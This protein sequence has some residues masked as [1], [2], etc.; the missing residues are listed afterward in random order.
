MTESTIPAEIYADMHYYSEQNTKLLDLIMQDEGVR[1]KTPVFTKDAEILKIYHQCNDFLTDTDPTSAQYKDF[2]PTLCS[3]PI[4]FGPEARQDIEDFMAM[5]PEALTEVVLNFT[6]N[7]EHFSQYFGVPGFF[8]SLLKSMRF[9][10]K[11]LTMRHDMIRS[12]GVF[13]LIETNVGTNVGGWDLALFQE[14]YQ[15]LLEDIGFMARDESRAFE[16][17]SLIFK[18]I[19]SFAKEY[20]GEGFLGNVLLVHGGDQHTINHSDSVVKYCSDSFHKTLPEEESANIEVITSLSNV[21][22]DPSG[23]VTYNGKL[24]DLIML[25]DATGDEASAF[26]MRLTSS[27][28]AKK[29]FFLD[30]PVHQVFGS[31]MIMAA[32]HQMAREGRLL[33]KH[34]QWIQ[35]HIPFTASL[36]DEY[37][38]FNN[39]KL[40]LTEFAKK[41]KDQFV[42][43]KG[44]SAQGKD[45]ILGKNET[46]QSWL[47]IILKEDRSSGWIFQEY[48]QAEKIINTHKELGLAEFDLIWGLFSVNSHYSGGFGRVSPSKSCDGVINSCRGAKE[49]AILEIEK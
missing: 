42:F 8:H 48:C 17:M 18:E 39:E 34:A 37:F 47:E 12:E 32:A 4:F 35:R 28:I 46:T 16:P 24:F 10:P 33:D 30:N 6:D 27:H 36:S 22:F 13:K 14:D 26:I 9:E 31:K 7:A 11:R 49:I 15:L 25:A 23:K 29:V 20:C 44:D 45:V 40:E 41:Y 2:P 38:Y 19:Y 21:G 3:W 43:K 1:V 5:M